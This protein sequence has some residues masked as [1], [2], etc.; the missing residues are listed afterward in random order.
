MTA[1]EIIVA[2]QLQPLPR[3]GGYFAV[4]YTADEKLQLTELPSRYQ[5]PRDMSGAIFYLETA[6][7]FSAMHRLPTD[8][9]YYYHYG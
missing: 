9:L 3:E 2:L 8:E 4:S 6:A 5:D 1:E 7:Q